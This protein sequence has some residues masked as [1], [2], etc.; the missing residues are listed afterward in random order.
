MRR[1]DVQVTE[2]VESGAPMVPP[3]QER[4]GVLV[5]RAWLESTDRSRFR[6]RI[7]QTPDLNVGLEV[8][9]SAATTE[10]VLDAV[11]AWLKTFS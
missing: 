6:A 3:P 5:I 9:T 11:L 8:T 4:A 2:D 7:V 10:A 1:G